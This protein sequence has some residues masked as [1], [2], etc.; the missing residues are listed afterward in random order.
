M[1]NSSRDSQVESMRMKT[2]FLTQIR[3]VGKIAHLT[4]SCFDAHLLKHIQIQ[5]QQSFSENPKLAKVK[6]ILLVPERKFKR[7]TN[8]QK[9]MKLVRLLDQVEPDFNMFKMPIVD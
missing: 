4:V 2:V 5:G 9:L 3:Q 1:S 8:F 6:N 7:K